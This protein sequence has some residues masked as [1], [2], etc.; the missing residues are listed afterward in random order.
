MV[1]QVGKWRRELGQLSKIG[2]RSSYVELFG[3]C[4]L[5][6]DQELVL[7]GPI[8]L[9]AL[10][11]LHYRIAGSVEHKFANQNLLTFLS[12]YPQ[13]FLCAAIADAS[14]LDNN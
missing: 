6:G 11:E 7:L 5:G 13:D 1:I 8:L 4:G 9:R 12:H 10:G 14:D 2:Y 3:G